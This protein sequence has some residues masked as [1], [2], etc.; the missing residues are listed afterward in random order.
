M[1]FRFRRSISLIPGV[2]LNL[3]GSGASV[4]LRP[5]GLRYTIGPK[6][7]RL[8]AGLPGTGVSWSQYTPHSKPP[9]PGEREDYS[10]AQ[11]FSAPLVQ[12]SSEPALATIE[13]ASA[14]QINALSA[15]E[16]A[17]IL[18]AVNRRYRISVAVQLVSV[19]LFVGALLQ[20]DQLAM[21]T[22][23]LYAT[24]FVPAAVM[25]DRYRR[26]VKVVYE[27]KGAVGQIADALAQSFNELIES[28][29]VWKVEAEGRTFD[30]K[31]NAGA[32]S[33]NRR[34]RIQPGFAKPHCIRGKLKFPTLN[35]GSEEI[36][37]LPD[38]ALIIAQGSVAA[39]GYHELQIANVPTKF[40]EEER[41][42]SDALIVGQTW[43]YVNKSGGPDRRFNGNRQ[44]PVCLY[45]ELTIWS[46][47]GLN[48]KIQYS[49]PSA[50]DK[51]CTVVDILHRTTA[52]FPKS[53]V[54]LERPK[55]SRSVVFLSCAGILAA[56]QL[57]L[58]V[59]KRPPEAPRQHVQSA[60]QQKPIYL[61]APP[62]QPIPKSAERRDGPEAGS[63]QAMAPV[64]APQNPATD[65]GVAKP[66]IGPVPLPRARP[67]F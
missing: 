13:S 53:I 56:V 33:L 39:V 37:L 43:R 45:G 65:S 60:T 10:P 23:A 21:A 30:W 15:S 54:Y 35:L 2:R 31:R 1:G 49:N 42:S 59:S 40:I 55:R 64:A 46:A 12:L 9:A 48:C 51:L 6:G 7:T 52:E 24:I 27:D 58:M 22:S 5:R 47:G 3:S 67:N 8:T 26:S 18:N 20:A 19:L 57:L 66:L 28:Q 25:L 36:Y 50:A 44:I 14:E 4:S 62:Q 41:V 16:L 29:S 38:A 63:Y 34:K 61:P 11:E 32:T 17:P